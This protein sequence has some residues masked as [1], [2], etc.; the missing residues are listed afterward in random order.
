M[1]RGGVAR[2][3]PGRSGPNRPVNDSNAPFASEGQSFLRLPQNFA[4]KMFA[5]S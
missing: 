1:G 2:Q 3:M 5:R 4:E